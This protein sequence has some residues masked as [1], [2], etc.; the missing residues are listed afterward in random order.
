MTPNLVNLLKKSDNLK[1]HK[2]KYEND[3]DFWNQHKKDYKNSATKTYLTMILKKDENTF[4]ASK[5]K[6]SSICLFKYFKILLLTTLYQIYPELWSESAIKQ[7]IFKK[8]I[9]SQHWIWKVISPREIPCLISGSL[10]WKQT[11][12]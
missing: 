6:I 8:I 11:F 2:I 12:I 1:V 9:C 7:A 5:N 3:Q 4:Q 10:K